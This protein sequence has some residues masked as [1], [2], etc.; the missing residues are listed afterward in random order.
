[1]HTVEHDIAAKQSITE[2]IYRYCRALDRMDRALADTVWHADGTADYGATFQGSA[3]GLLDTMWENH[4]KLLG[5]SHQVTNILIELDGDRA[6]SESYAYGTLWNVAPNGVLVR[7]E[8]L[9]RYLD[10]WSCRDGVWAIDHR[11]FVYDA[12]FTAANVSP[13]D[14]GDDPL[15]RLAAKRDP[16]QTLGRRD[17]TDPSYLVLG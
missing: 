10:T 17:R 3:S 6:G 11:H 15:I 7:L 2:V 8:A 12:V 4:A 14:A 1:M 16:L 13:D 9:G 5:H